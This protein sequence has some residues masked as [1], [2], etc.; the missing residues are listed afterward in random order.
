M[1]ADLRRLRPPLPPSSAHQSLHL[2][3]PLSSPSP[4]LSPPPSPRPIVPCITHA[5]ASTGHCHRPL[6]PSLPLSLRRTASSWWCGGGGGVRTVSQR[7][8]PSEPQGPSV[9]HEPELNFFG[10]S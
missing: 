5:Q 7:H 9:E 4:L 2:H 3:P 1:G 10:S 8:P 6:C